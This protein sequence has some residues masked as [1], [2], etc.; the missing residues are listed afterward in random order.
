MVNG[1]V[2]APPAPALGTVTLAPHRAPAAPHRMKYLA[3][4]WWYLSPGL[5]FSVP[6]PVIAPFVFIQTGEVQGL[7]YSDSG[8]LATAWAARRMGIWGESGW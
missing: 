1:P 2:V 6:L 4:A 5:P 3:Q 7:A 8:H